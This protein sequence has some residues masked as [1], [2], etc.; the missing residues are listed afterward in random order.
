MEQGREP[1]H[2]LSIFTNFSDAFL[3]LNGNRNELKTEG[4]LFLEIDFGKLNSISELTRELMIE[5]REVNES[6]AKGFQT[7]A[8]CCS[9]Y[10]RSSF[11]L[12]KNNVT[13]LWH[14]KY[15]ITMQALS[16]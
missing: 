7:E 6:H 12:F 11:I 1:S 16:Q 9:L 10:F 15:V 5:V 13:Y 4:M 2:F 3:I 8:K 14:G